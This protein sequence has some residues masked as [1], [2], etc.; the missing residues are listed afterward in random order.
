MGTSALSAGETDDRAGDSAAGV[1]G[2]SSGDEG[3]LPPAAASE[4]SG[5]SRVPLVLSGLALVVAALGGWQVFEQRIAAK[6]LRDEVATRLNQADV[7]VAEL[8]GLS[9]QQQEMIVAVQGRLGALDAQIAATEGQ[10]AALEA[11]Y[12]EYSRSRGDQVLAEVEQAINIAAQQLQLAGNYEAAV[13]ALEGADARLSQP[14]QGHL[15]A[16]RRALI[17]DLD[18][19]KAHPRVDVSG[20]ALRLEILLER[21]DALPLAYEFTLDESAALGDESPAVEVDPSAPVWERGW[22]YTQAVASDVWSEIKGMVRLERLDQS[23]P[24]LLSP[25]QST[26][27][28]ENVKIRLLTARLAL[29]AQ[30]GRTYAADL[31][32]AR[33][34]VERFF[35]VREESV[36]RVI[37]DLEELGKLQ[38][39]AEVPS[40]EETFAALRVVQARGAVPASPVP[41]ATTQP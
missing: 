21:M 16:L 8:R 17:K 10:A 26:F 38:I 15:Q 41:S 14:D 18:A 20:L 2:P 9:K 35:D 40:L 12:Q 1:N 11:L 29:L 37:A 22:A 33:Q 30:D 6:E 28:R 34:W 7:T 13:I 27:L 24:A 39:S 3:M 31:A 4:S 25:A 19:I 36:Q 23:D 5:G 32:Q